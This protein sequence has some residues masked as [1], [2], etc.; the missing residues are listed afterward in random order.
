MP[1][2]VWDRLKKTPAVS[3]HLVRVGGVE[4]WPRHVVRDYTLPR[5]APAPAA[6]GAAGPRARG[7]RLPATSCPRASHSS[8]TPTPPSPRPTSPTASAYTAPPH[9]PH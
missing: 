4:H 8:W 3:K 2:S 1:L 7:T 5:P 9:M 6:L